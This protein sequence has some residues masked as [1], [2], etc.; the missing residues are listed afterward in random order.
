M[1]M[2]PYDQS[3]QEKSRLE[4]K[5]RV[6]ENDKAVLQRALEQITTERT[7]I[8]Q[9]SKEVG[10]ENQTLLAKN[11]QLKKNISDLKQV[12]EKHQKQNKTIEQKLT[13]YKGFVG[14]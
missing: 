4:E 3:Q 9:Q 6:L 14:N 10:L 13:T 1:Y 7:E 8:F 2:I 12:I 11:V 5:I